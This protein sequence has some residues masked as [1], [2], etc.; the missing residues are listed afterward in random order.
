MKVGL[1]YWNTI[2]HNPEAFRALASALLLAGHEVYVV[3]AVGHRR[4]Q[5]VLDEI[6]ALNFPQTGVRMVVFD[7]PRD[8]PRLKY[9]V[10][11]ELGISVF[12]D[13]RTD[14]CAYLNER[15]I[16]VCHVLKRQEPKTA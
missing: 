9:E 7:H 15:G 16:L 2:S 13:D 12:F 5:T 1:D 14:T 11:H 4:K 10:C 8:A 6:A 3:T